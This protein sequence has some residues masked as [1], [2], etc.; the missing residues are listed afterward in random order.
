MFHLLAYTNAPAGAVVLTN[1]GMV[2]DGAI[3]QGSTG[4]RLTE[5]YRALGAYAHAALLTQAELRSPTLN[6]LALWNV[7]PT[8]TSLNNPANPN[9]D[10]YRAFAPRLPMYEDISAVYSD[11]AVGGERADLFLWLGTDG[12]SA[13]LSVLQ[14]MYGQGDPYIGRRIAVNS[15]TTLNKG[16]AT[17]G[18]DA[19][20]TFEQLPR[21]GVYAVVGANIVAAACPAFRINFTRQPL[22]RGRKL[23][24]GDLC[25][26]AYGDVP[27]KMG[28]NAWGIWGVFHTWELPFASLYGQA[29]GTQA[30]NG[31]IDLVY[32]GG[33][34]DPQGVLNNALTV[35]SNAA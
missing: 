9:V 33:N 7:Y 5:P 28:R 20:L 22:Y 35:L 13:D 31:V 23:F 34:Q 24:P 32:L 27:H 3:A 14:A 1:M 6:G 29:A 4:Y 12:W 10:D 30:I 16:L 8:A 18:A 2:A 11:T 25:S 26:Q 17:W 19:A 15:T 21:G